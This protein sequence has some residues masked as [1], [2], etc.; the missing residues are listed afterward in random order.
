M[1]WQIWKKASGGSVRLEAAE[2]SLVAAG[3][4]PRAAGLLVAAG[5]TSVGAV[6]EAL[7]TTEDAGRRYESAE[8][9]LSVQPGS[10]PAIMADIQ[11]FRDQLVQVH[12]PATL[13]GDD[14]LR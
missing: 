7:W 12:A 11:R 2:E 4:S 1:N 5:Y 10:T 3:A 13:Q 6:R 8:W 14:P 9:R